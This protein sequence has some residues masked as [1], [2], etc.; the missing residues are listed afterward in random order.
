MTEQQVVNVEFLPGVLPIHPPTIACEVWYVC[1]DAGGNVTHKGEPWT[2]WFGGG[3][4]EGGSVRPS[5]HGATF[6]EDAYACE[7]P[8]EHES[9]RI[10]TTLILNTFKLKGLVRAPRNSNWVCVDVVHIEETPSVENRHPEF[11]VTRT[12]ACGRAPR[13]GGWLPLLKASDVRLSDFLEKQSQSKYEEGKI[14]CGDNRTKVQ[15][16]WQ[17]DCDHMQKVFQAYVDVLNSDEFKGNES[18]LREN[19]INAGTSTKQFAQTV[20]LPYWLTNSTCM[21]LPGFL[22]AWGNGLRCSTDWV[23]HIFQCMFRRVDRRVPSVLKNKKLHRRVLM[24]AIRAWALTRPY[25]PDRFMDFH[26]DENV[27]N[28][29]T[30]W[31]T[32]TGAN[33]CEDFAR[34]I[35]QT[36][37]F[38]QNLEVGEHKHRVFLESVRVLA[39]EFV[40]MVVFGLFHNPE[41]CVW[42]L[43]HYE[44][45]GSIGGPKGQRFPH[46]FVHIASRPL[47]D[48]WRGENPNPKPTEIHQY[49]IDSVGLFNV[50]Q[51]AMDYGEDRTTILDEFSRREKYDGI[52]HLEH[53]Q[54]FVH[55]TVGQQEVAL[56]RLFDT[57][58][59]VVADGKVPARFVCREKGCTR[60]KLTDLITDP[61]KYGLRSMNFEFS[62]NDHTAAKRLMAWDRPR[63]WLLASPAKHA[64]KSAV[65]AT[66]CDRLC[67]G[68]SLKPHRL[69]RP[70]HSD[71]YDRVVVNL[72][73]R[74]SALVSRYPRFG[75]PHAHGITELVQLIQTANKELVWVDVLPDVGRFFV[76]KLM[77]RVRAN[78]GDRQLKL[79][80]KNEGES[81]PHQ[82]ELRTFQS[83]GAG[84]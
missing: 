27:N 64:A 5:R 77:F 50:T 7:P 16:P 34:L 29:A 46:S 14:W 80:G 75:E 13:A 81:A 36:L 19:A 48:Y 39:N 59:T 57:I 65:A 4:G 56:P 6:L 30:T 83:S 79:K 31:P 25:V 53:R 68:L 2:F 8:Q 41:G 24:R 61:L 23:Y 26:T 66:I 67:S 10:E 58:T 82:H 63:S 49:I 32:D 47:Y 43:R 55:A 22:M 54:S 69:P 60:L 51:G 33:D 18:E 76:V 38:F 15:K 35:Q 52:W 37:I 71:K 40:P 45:E 70:G 9:V 44:N 74:S 84:A 1:C 28:D 42:R 17:A 62:E 11:Y 73:V 12:R 72:F 3:E 21:F 78:Q 20:L